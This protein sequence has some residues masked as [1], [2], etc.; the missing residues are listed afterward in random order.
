VGSLCLATKKKSSV[1]CQ[2]FCRQTCSLQTCLKPVRMRV[3]CPE[4]ILSLCS[5]PTFWTHEYRKY[6]I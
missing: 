5:P 4:S 3:L 2:A 1:Q 6:Q